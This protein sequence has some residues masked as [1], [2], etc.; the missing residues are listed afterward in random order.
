MASFFNEKVIVLQ[1]SKRGNIQ[2]S[3]L[4]FKD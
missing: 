4:G 3:E 2:L 1:I